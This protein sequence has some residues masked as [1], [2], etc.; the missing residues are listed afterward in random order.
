[1]SIGILSEAPAYVVEEFAP[2]PADHGRRLTGL[3]RTQLN[4]LACG[5]PGTT[6]ER[7]RSAVAARVRTQS[8]ETPQPSHPQQGETRSTRL[9]LSRSLSTFA[10]RVAR[11]RRYCSRRRRGSERN[12][13]AGTSRCRN[14]QLRPRLAAA[15]RIR[16]NTIRGRHAT[17]EPVAQAPEPGRAIWR[18]TPHCAAP[19]S[20][21]C[22]DQPKSSRNDSRQPGTASARSTTSVRS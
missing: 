20:S 7:S 5:T 16:G 2:R 8:A 12:A 3:V 15:V 17:A 19:P 6:R 1:V 10:F 9:P 11:L 4:R 22:F 18:A 21:A 13:E 14:R